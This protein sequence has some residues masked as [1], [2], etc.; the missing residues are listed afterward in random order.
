MNFLKTANLAN[1]GLATETIFTGAKIVELTS[2]IK[3]LNKKNIKLQ[4]KIAEL[5]NHIRTV[6]NRSIYTFGET[7]ITNYLLGLDFNALQ[8]DL[9][10]LTKPLLL[11]QVVIKHLN[12]KII[13]THTS[14]N[15]FKLSVSI[16]FRNNHENIISFDIDNSILK[17]VALSSNYNIAKLKFTVNFQITLSVENTLTISSDIELNE[18]DTVK[19]NFLS[20][21][22]GPVIDAEIKKAV[23][24]LLVTG[25]F[26]PFEFHSAQFNSII[27]TIIKE[28]ATSLVVANEPRTSRET[29]DSARASGDHVQTEKER[30]EAQQR[31]TEIFD[32]SNRNAAVEEARLNAATAQAKTVE[33]DIR[34]TKT[35]MEAQLATLQLAKQQLATRQLSSEPDDEDNEDL[36]SASPG[37]S[38]SPSPNANA[39]G[40]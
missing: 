20:S 34:A 40:K 30:L 18:L 32:E 12:V 5:N 11:R 39:I 19:I 37:F 6:A 24:R 28:A 4:E 3:K 16:E 23:Q 38:P 10:V 17:V 35:Q 26:Q 29:N 7:L 1:Y 14:S 9:T 25:R 33:E 22:T 27:S 36:F 21:V 15:S 8:P 13:E 31:Y 2:Q